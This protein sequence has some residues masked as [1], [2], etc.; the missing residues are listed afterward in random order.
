MNR[1]AGGILAIV[2]VFASVAAWIADG[3]LDG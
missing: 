2:V 3:A 1:R